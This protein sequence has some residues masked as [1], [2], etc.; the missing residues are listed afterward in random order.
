[1]LFKSQNV[2]YLT[3]RIQRKRTVHQLIKKTQD[4]VLF[5]PLTERYRA[6]CTGIQRNLSIKYKE[7]KGQCAISELAVPF[8][9]FLLD[10]RVGCST[11]VNLM[12]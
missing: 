8:R 2:R 6:W 7:K 1:M 5:T 9:T 4:V 10:F 11:M 3:R 12:K